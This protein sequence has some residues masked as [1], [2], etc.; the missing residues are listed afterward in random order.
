MNKFR[1]LCI[2]QGATNT[3]SQVGVAPKISSVAP[4]TVWSA[5]LKS[6]IL[7]NHV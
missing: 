1:T 3:I 2:K 7:Y 6:F 5:V 4:S